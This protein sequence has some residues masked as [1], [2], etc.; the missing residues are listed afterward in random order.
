MILF[1]CL[2][3]QTFLTAPGISALGIILN[4]GIP[5]EDNFKTEIIKIS[6]AVVL[7]L[8]RQLILS[9]GARLTLGM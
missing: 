5:S 7:V 1:G 9:E 4:S 2:Q 3:N 8:S 6:E